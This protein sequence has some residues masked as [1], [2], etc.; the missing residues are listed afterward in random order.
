MVKPDQE[1]YTSCGPFRTAVRSRLIFRAEINKEIKSTLKEKD[2]M[3]QQIPI[4]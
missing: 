3:L 1:I 2:S 4:H